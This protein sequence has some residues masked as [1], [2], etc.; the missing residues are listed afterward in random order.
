MRKQKGQ[1]TLEQAVLIIIIM[2][3]LISVGAYFKRGVQGRW[4]T[5]VDG[6]GDQYDPSVTNMDILETL[7]SNTETRLTTFQDVS[8]IWTIRS[9][10]AVSQASTTGTTR[11]GPF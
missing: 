10:N 6:L 9:D 7:S 5:A 8:G 3:A 2:G 11:V 1:T 4:K